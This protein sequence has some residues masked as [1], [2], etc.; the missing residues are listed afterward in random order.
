MKRLN[1]LL[2]TNTRVLR[3]REAF[4]NG[5]S[6]N[7]K[8]FKTE[9]HKIGQSGGTVSRLLKPLLKTE[10]PLMKNILKPLAK[11]VWIRVG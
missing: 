2:L 10:L 7:I 8:L 1:K 6:A 5:S 3:L 4:T 11:S 9:L